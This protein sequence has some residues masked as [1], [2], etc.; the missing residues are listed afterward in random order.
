MSV[1]KNKAATLQEAA[2]YVQMHG[3]EFNLPK[4]G[5]YVCDSFHVDEVEEDI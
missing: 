2:K 3:A 1:S 5:Q 4:E